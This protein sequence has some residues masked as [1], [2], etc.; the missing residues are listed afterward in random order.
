MWHIEQDGQPKGPYTDEQM[1]A[2]VEAKVVRK[3]TLTWKQG[4]ANWLPLSETDFALKDL[5]A[6]GAAPP[7][8]AS[9]G[10][11]EARGTGRMVAP[12]GLSMWRLFIRG[13]SSRYAGFQGRA[14]RKEYWSF[15]LFY[16]LAL[17]AAAVLGAGIDYAM[18]NFSGDTADRKAIIVVIAFVIVLFGLLLPHL[19]VLVRRLH[20][21]GLSGWLVLLNLIPYLGGIVVLVLTLLPSEA[22]ENKHG[23]G[24]IAPSPGQ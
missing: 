11:S 21:V 16:W 18:G 8:L 23:P 17:L 19:A 2:L 24:T 9:T 10:N 6:D 22:A 3:G 4:M 5:A 1:K 7:T 13:I 15:V 12:E 14:K 20:D